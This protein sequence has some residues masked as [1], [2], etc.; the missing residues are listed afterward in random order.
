[1]LSCLGGAGL[2]QRLHAEWRDSGTLFEPAEAWS[3]PARAWIWLPQ[4]GRRPAS[5]AELG[6]GAALAAVTAAIEQAHPDLRGRYHRR[7][8]A[9]LAEYRA[10]EAEAFGDDD[11]PDAA[12]AAQAPQDTVERLWP[13]VIAYAVAMLTQQAERPGHRDPWH[14]LQS[15]ELGECIDAL[16]PDLDSYLAETVLRVGILAILEVLDPASEHG[17]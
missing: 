10:E 7:R 12:A 6:C 13:A 15:F 9:K 16:A 14:V 1:M 4:A 2:Q 17:Q 8:D 11:D 5:L 3:D